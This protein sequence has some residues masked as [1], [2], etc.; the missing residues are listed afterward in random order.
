MSTIHDHNFPKFNELPPKE[1]QR[2][3]RLFKQLDVTNDNK[4]TA[5]DLAVAFKEMGI[6]YNPDGYN[7]SGH[8]S[9][10]KRTE[11]SLITRVEKL[12]SLSFDD[13]FHF[14]QETEH[15]LMYLF[16]YMDENRD[17]IIDAD[18]I[19]S[20]FERFN[21][22]IDKKEAFVL[23]K[24]MDKDDSQTISFNEW[25]D[26]LL[27]LPSFDI[28]HIL[29]SWRHATVKKFLDLGENVLVPEDFTSHEMRTG[30]WWRHLVAGGLAGAVSRTCTAPLD[31]IKVFL[32]VR[33]SEY[34]TINACLRHM[35]KEGGIP[36]LWRGNGINVLKIAPES[37][38]KFMAYEQAK[39][40]IRGNTGRE[41]E[42]YERFI[43]GS[44]AG[45]IS[46]TLIYPLEV[47]KTR[48]ALR[49]TG[50]YTSI[51]DATCKIYKKEGLRSFYR[52]YLPNLLGIIPYAGIDLAIYETLKKTYVSRHPEE[53]DPGILVLLGCG[54]VSSSCG[55]IASYPLALVRT[56]LQAQAVT[57]DSTTR[58][59]SSMI[60]LF[61]NIVKREGVSGLYR[62]ITP[63][64]MKVAPAVSIS[65]VVY[66]YSRRALGVTMA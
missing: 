3:V 36:S 41:L 40:L 30:M 52:G 61:K 5:E 26:Y 17:G 10:T 13:F 56:R 20:A 60:G 31:R 23:L 24:R 45:G 47:L 48:L 63:N 34:S 16:K 62:G 55:Q 27:F 29:N 4:I 15:Q 50:E 44:L 37:A 57:N 38:L 6:P 25:R 35:L 18:E 12:G 43:A 33:G 42:I 7:Q 39:R 2:L 32:Q 9:G 21:I 64:F 14:I 58:E 54:T 66:E 1:Q 11:S 53:T 59:A 65:Y 46:Q 19:V 49:K 51:W 8:D 22:S 28:R